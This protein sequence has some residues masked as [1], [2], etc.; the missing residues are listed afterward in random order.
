MG[1]LIGQLPAPRAAAQGVEVSINLGSQAG[2]HA[3][4]VKLGIEL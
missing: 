2:L 1:P 3:G 4:I